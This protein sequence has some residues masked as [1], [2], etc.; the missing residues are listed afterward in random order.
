[1]SQGM[2]GPPMRT[3]PA[4]QTLVLALALG[5]MVGWLLHI[6]RSIIVPLVV[7]VVVVYVIIGLARFLDHVPLI[8]HHIPGWAR[9]VFSI[10]V[11]VAGLGTIVSLI[12]SNV[13]QVAAVAP[14]YES[15]LLGFAQQISEIFGFETQPTWT[16]IRDQVLN[17]IEFGTLI[18]AAVA[19]LSG[20]VGVSAVVMI[21]VS[22][23]LA[24]RASFAAKIANLSR[25]PETLAEVNGVIRA[26]NKRVSH[27]LALKTLINILLGFV[28]WVAMSLAGV[29]FAAFWAVLIGLLNYIPYVGSFIG[30]TFPVLLSV[31]QFADFGTVLM[32]LLALTGVQIMVGNFIEPYVMG[33]SLN[34]S[35]TVILIGLA[36]WGGLWGIPGAILSVPITASLVIVFASFET[37]RPVAVLLSAK[38]EVGEPIDRG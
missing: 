36:F 14:R 28:S 13:N 4:L 20:F 3:P 2:A 31:V 34:L 11:I 26:V 17:Q 29:E 32:I 6:G 8:G 16:T 38:G 24:E 37:T 22:F 23:L 35:P 33:N 12:V 1:M 18:R 9:H 15:T 21:Y 7:A 27:Y 5:I 25:D 30:V 10:L 19:S